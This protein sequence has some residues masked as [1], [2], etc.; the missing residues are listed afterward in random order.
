MAK[1]HN[2]SVKK[3][4]NRLILAGTLLLGSSFIF[5]GSAIAADETLALGG[6][7]DTILEVGQKLAFDRKKG[8]CLA[9]HTV[10]GGISPGNIAPALIAMSTRYKNKKELKDQIYDATAANPESAMP[11]FGKHGVISDKELNAIVEFIWSL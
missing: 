4:Q 6:A 9:C 7:E 8:N 1:P 11:P 10:G 3:V 2:K 5:S